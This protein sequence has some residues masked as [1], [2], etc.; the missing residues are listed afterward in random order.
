MQAKH[1]LFWHHLSQACEAL[2]PG[3]MTRVVS[4][5]LTELFL[6]REYK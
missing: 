2:T 4:I 6:N 3:R 5:L 1:F